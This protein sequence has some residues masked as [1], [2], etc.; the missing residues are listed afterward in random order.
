MSDIEVTYKNTFGMDLGSGY[1]CCAVYIDGRPEVVVNPS[2]GRTTPSVVSFRGEERLV[3]DAAVSQGISNSKNTIY[4][5]KRMIGRNYSDA[6][7]Q[8]ELKYWPYKV[9]QGDNDRPAIV[10]EYGGEEKRFSPEEISAM[11]ISYCRTYVEKFTG[12]TMRNVVI[13]V[14]SYFSDR[15]R[16]A[17]KDA[18][19]IAGL[20]VIRIVNEPTA[21]AL[22]YGF[23]K[24]GQAKTIICWDLGSCTFDVSLLRVEDGIFEVLATHGNS[25]LGGLDFDHRMVQHLV[26]EI[27]NKHKV[28][29]SKNARALKRLKVACEKAKRVLSSSTTATIEIDSLDTDLDFTYQFSRAKFESLN[30]DLF[31]Q[32]MDVV[33]QV[34]SD[35][36]MSASE[37]DEVILVG[38]S[39]R[40][41]KVQALLSE[42]FKGKKLNSSV[43][44]DECVAVGA[45][46]QAAVLSGVKDEKLS[47]LLLLDVCSLSLGLET[48]GGVMTKIIPRN[49]TLPTKKVQT[50]STAADNQP[51]VLVQVY[52]GERALTK[53]CN[54]LGQFFLD[55][56]PPMPRGVPQIEISYDIGL[57]GILKVTAVEKSTGKS[58]NIC[59][60]NDRNRLSKEDIDRLVEEAE[61]Y[62]EFDKKITRRIEAKNTLESFTLQTKTLLDTPADA[63][64]PLTKDTKDELENALKNTEEWLSAHGEEDAE[65][66]ENK[67]SELKAL[68][69]K[70][71]QNLG[72]STQ[73]PVTNPPY[74]EGERDEGPSDKSFEPKNVEE[75]D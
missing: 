44:P 3:G 19:A 39:S 50:F 24:Q 48:A 9:E 66:Y 20:N 64:S 68:V 27:K 12:E 72:A 45:A 61:K 71:Y 18:G 32:T 34:L 74:S 58:E 29:I 57:D 37:V 13:T 75:I 36:K 43:N 6:V 33:T 17:T 60:T 63:N 73:N 10:V 26:N 15:Q 21:S 4:E 11:V 41:P 42:F 38:G 30:S 25:H 31:N 5:V 59:I 2:G 46:I 54:Q 65:V 49:T 70:L 53:D 67:L 56:L 35:A 47:D 52:E 62:A 69:E 40:I 8:A 7:V 28:D 16:Q 14:P 55:N 1:S 23:D 22:A 51:S